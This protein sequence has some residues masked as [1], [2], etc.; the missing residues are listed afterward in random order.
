MKK[1]N[2]VGKQIFAVCLSLIMVLT[3]CISPVSAAEAPNS[4]TVK[5]TK[6]MESYIGENNGFTAYATTDGVIVYCMDLH[7]DGATSGTHYTYLKE[8][9]QGLLYLMKNGYPNKRITNTEEIDQYI[10]QS[11]VWWYLDDVSGAG[12]LSEAFQTTDKEAYVGIRNEIVKLVNA[13]KVA[14]KPSTPTMT[15]TI[16]NSNLKLTEDGKYYESN[17]VT[18]DLNG[19][20]EYKVNI[21]NKSAKAVNENGEEK[22]TF[23][24]GEKFK[25]RL[26]ADSVKENI[27]L[28]VNVTA[29]GEVESV[30]TFNP[31]N[32]AFQRVVSSKIYTKNVKLEKKLT[33]S[34]AGN[35]STPTI[36]TTPAEEDAVIVD[37]PNTLA[38]SSLFAI[39][40]G[41]VLVIAGGSLI[42]Y[43]Y[44]TNKN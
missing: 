25:I 12:N 22:T 6:V 35:G 38:N 44:R 39:V 33:L 37:V 19:A 2:K 16:T 18:V 30:A 7:K 42:I 20:K 26:N 9:D 5:R 28:D 1:L 31:D 23:S 17:P 11:A 15:V 3:L 14:S 21:N 32:S 24:A 29:T 10:T 4:M 43:R 27:N 41:V 36:S 40:A 13:A 8:G 34:A